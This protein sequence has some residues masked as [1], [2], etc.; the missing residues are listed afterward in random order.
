IKYKADGMQPDSL[1]PGIVTIRCSANDLDIAPVEVS[2]PV[3]Y[4][5]DPPDEGGSIVVEFDKENYKPGETAVANCKWL[6]GYDELIDFPI[7]QRFT[8]EITG[9]IEYGVL[10]DAE[11][12]VVSNILED[13]SNDF[14]VITA[15]E[16]AEEEARIILKVRT[17][18]GGDIPTSALKQKDTEA[19]ERNNRGENSTIT[20]ELLVIGGEEI[21]GY[22]TVVV[23]K[24][25]CVEEIVVCINYQPPKFEDVGTITILGENDSWQWI[26]NQGNSQTTYTGSACDYQ[27]DPSEFGKTYIMPKIGDFA[28]GNLVYNLLDDTKVTVCQDKNDPT[29][30]I[31]RYSV[32]NLRVPIFRDHCPA[33]AI[34]NDYV[35]LLDGTNADTLAKYI[36]NCSD[37]I[38][39]MATLDWWKKGPYYQPKQSPPYNFY[40]SAGVIAHENIHVKQ[41]KDGGTKYFPVGSIYNE[42]NNGSKG[43]RALALYKYS[44]IIAKCPEDALVAVQG[45]GTM[46]ERVKIQLDAALTV[47]NDLKSLGGQD[48][49]GRYNSELEAD[50]YARPKYDEIK[51]NIENWAKQQSWWCDP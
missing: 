31:W 27:I 10:Q 40:F 3:K 39:V 46:E 26:D 42:M 17:T 19:E 8:V 22:G 1:N 21:I 33:W 35:D 32:E 12:G 47:A 24:D 14:R 51:T 41:M 45:T 50:E 16:I 36:K 44:A 4:N 13:V 25:G 37:Y 2:F 43:F 11:T 29:D 30:P 28:P 38:K 6:T 5:T 23:K 9:G 15:T 34:A 18:V 7:D 48:N 20:P 49:Q